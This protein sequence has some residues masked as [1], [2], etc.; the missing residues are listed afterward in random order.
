MDIK[1]VVVMEE[2]SDDMEIKPQLSIFLF[3]I[4]PWPLKAQRG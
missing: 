4:G 1:A 3:L 2:A